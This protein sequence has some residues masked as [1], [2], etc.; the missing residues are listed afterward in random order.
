MKYWEKPDKILEEKIEEFVENFFFL[1]YRNFVH[2]KFKKSKFK[3][4]TTLL[5][6]KL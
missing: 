6:K 1:N 3:V 2:R 5:D 4:I